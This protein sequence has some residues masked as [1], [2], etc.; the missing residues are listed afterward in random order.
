MEILQ[1]IDHRDQHDDNPGNVTLSPKESEDSEFITAYSNMIDVD[2]LESSSFEDDSVSET[3]L[4]EP[5]I[6]HFTTDV[7]IPVIPDDLRAKSI[8]AEEVLPP[9]LPDNEPLKIEVLSTES[10]TVLSVST[11]TAH[12][13]DCETIPSAPLTQQTSAPTIP[14]VTTPIVL[15][16]DISK[17]VQPP[18]NSKLKDIKNFIIN[19]SQNTISRNPFE[20]CLDTSQQALP[21]QTSQLHSLS[22]QP[23]Q[24]QLQARRQVH[25]ALQTSQFQ[26]LQQQSA[27]QYQFTNPQQLFA[28]QHVKQQRIRS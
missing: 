22:L 5:V 20:I 25:Q 15:P 17:N 3:D 11:E 7:Q 9:Q 24:S 23:S 16:Q 27:S 14:E 6:S 26:S 4:C 13:H 18:D 21:L 2:L 8:T 10:N 28:S 1:S 19:Q 12:S